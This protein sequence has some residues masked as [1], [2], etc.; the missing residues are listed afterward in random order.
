MK[1]IQRKK[2]LKENVEKTTNNISIFQI[3]EMEQMEQRSVVLFLRSKGL[4]KKAIHHEFVA[5]LQENAVSC[6]TRV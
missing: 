3:V 5:V 4:S 2:S 6:S 1:E